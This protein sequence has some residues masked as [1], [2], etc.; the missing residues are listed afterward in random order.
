MRSLHRS[1][2]DGGEAP[3][4]SRRRRSSRRED[5]TVDSR[6]FRALLEGLGEVRN[7]GAHP[8][9]LAPER[10]E[11]MFRL[12]YDGGA[13]LVARADQP[14]C[15]L[16]LVKQVSAGAHPRALSAEDRRVLSAAL[17][18]RTTKWIASELG[19]SASTVG[20]WRECALDRLGM[21]NIVELGVVLP[22][23]T[24]RTAASTCL[25][26][27]PVRIEGAELTLFVVTIPPLEP[28]NGLTDAER[29][30]V[31][32]VIEGRS[33]REIATE[34][35]TSSR[36]VANQLQ[37]AF[38]R[39]GVSGRGQLLRQCVEHTSKRTHLEGG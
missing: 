4:V 21:R 33:N 36:T 27:I 5:A 23:S 39:L 19:V 2:E 17:E 6:R 22:P 16:L 35:G 24:T 31:R 1:I 32:G 25:G 38:R 37:S 11:R 29:E 3:P 20:A 10:A 18:G 28:P 15:R 12:F 13:V 7:V 26:A 34:R 8:S 30:V 14:S 9:A